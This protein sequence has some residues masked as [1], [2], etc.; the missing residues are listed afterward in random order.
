MYFPWLL[1][2]FGSNQITCKEK[3]CRWLKSA[4]FETKTFE[5]ISHNLLSTKVHQG[6]VW[7]QTF[8]EVASVTEIIDFYDFSSDEFT[9]ASVFLNIILK[10][11]STLTSAN[12]ISN[13]KI[14]QRNHEIFCEK[15]PTSGYLRYSATMAVNRCVTLQSA[16]ISDSITRRIL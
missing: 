4:C 5:G 3:M 16:V 10:M 14:E 12:I 8:P 6:F 7:H 2:Y 11:V 13:S 15:S 1:F 9:F